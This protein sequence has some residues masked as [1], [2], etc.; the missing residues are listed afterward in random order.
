MTDVVIH[1]EILEQMIQHA[2]RD[3]PLECCG[4]LSGSGETI[5]HT[6]PASNQSQSPR[7]FS[8]SAKELFAFFKELRQ[9][10]RRHLG[11][12]HSHPRSG[13]LPSARDIEEYHYTDV[14]YWIISLENDEPD[15]GC[16]RWHQEGFERIPFRVVP[17]KV[18]TV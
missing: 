8:V 5:D 15:C 2:R 10:G 13:V 1:R 14:S 16:F 4:L 9:T 11:I 3:F 17:E 18:D 6:W 7:E 12:Y